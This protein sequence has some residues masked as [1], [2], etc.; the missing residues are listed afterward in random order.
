MVRAVCCLQV[1]A[2]NVSKKRTM[3]GGWRWQDDG[4]A[5]SLRRGETACEEANGGG[6]DI[7]LTARD[8]AG[9]AQPRLGSHP[10]RA[11]EKL[12]CVDKG[13]AV[14][15]TEAGELGS[16]KARD[17]TEDVHLLAVFKLGLNPHHIEQRAEPIVLA[18]LHH[19]IGFHSRSM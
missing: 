3:R 7:A 4:L 1:A 2:G 19:R 14:K 6:F 12:W 18:Q 10:Q 13:V 17:R 8:L 11:I 9:K 5:E 16:C 15:A